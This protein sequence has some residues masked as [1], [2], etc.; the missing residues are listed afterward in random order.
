MTGKS[1]LLRVCTPLAL[2]AWLPISAAAS[3]KT[4]AMLVV[5]RWV[6]TFNANDPQANSLTCGEDAVVVDDFPP[7]V[8]QGPGACSRWFA[9]YVAMAAQ[10]KITHARVVLGT[11]RHFDA[12]SGYAYLTAPV[13][14]SF[15]QAGKP[16][17]EMGVLT[18][19]MKKGNAGWRITGWSWAD[20]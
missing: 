11:A 5:H 18:L 9:D 16:V 3:D 1:L 14:L 19:A 20:Q 7:H 4:D 2:L 17:R 15:S 13:A 10:A 8:W 12:D 6:D